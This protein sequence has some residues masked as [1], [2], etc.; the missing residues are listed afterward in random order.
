[1]AGSLG[2]SPQPLTGRVKAA[3]LK[4][5]AAC[6]GSAATSC[7]AM[8]SEIITKDYQKAHASEMVIAIQLPPRG[9]RLQCPGSQI[10]PR[11]RGLRLWRFLAS[12]RPPLAV[13][14]LTA[15]AGSDQPGDRTTH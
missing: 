3:W 2:R 13:L 10:L 8:M 1:M 11:G 6:A 7:A 15:I 14:R 4:Y 9:T 12:G 5:A